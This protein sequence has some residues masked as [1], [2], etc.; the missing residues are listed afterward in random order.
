MTTTHKFPLQTFE[1]AGRAGSYDQ[2]A[3]Q[4]TYDINDPKPFRYEYRWN[5]EQQDP[6]FRNAAG[7]DNGQLVD[8]E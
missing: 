7:G 3:T 1:S 6:T 4:Y 8:Q 2:P 5:P